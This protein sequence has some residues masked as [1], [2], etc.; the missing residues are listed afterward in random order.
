MREYISLAKSY[1]ATPFLHCCGSAYRLIPE[2]I[3]MGIKILDPVQTVARNMEPARLKSEFGGRMAFH[4]GGETQGILPRG[5][6]DDVRQNAR[7]LS[8][9]LGKDG[10]YIMSS[11]HFMQSDVSIENVL[12]FYELENRS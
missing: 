6:A 3:D 7:M 8:Q 9:T 12:A 2:F 1:G 5:T 11:C 10:G 4:G